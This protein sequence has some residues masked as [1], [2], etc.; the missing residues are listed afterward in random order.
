MNVFGRIRRIAAGT[1][2][3][4]PSALWL[5]LAASGCSG[6][7]K[8]STVAVEGRVLLADGRPL[9]RGRVTFVSADVSAPPASGELGTDGAFRLT[10]RDP[11]DGAAPGTYRV[12]IEPAAAPGAPP[13]A[14]PPF[15]TRYVDEDSSGIV[16]TVRGEPNRLGPFY[17]K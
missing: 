13:D 12:R 4:C 5:A 17:L 3:L 14:A 16:V 15:P 2:V 1:C 8:V 10:T 11:G 6:E 7:G 9:S